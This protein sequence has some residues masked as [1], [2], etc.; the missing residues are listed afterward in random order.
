[1]ARWSSGTLCWVATTYPDSC[2]SC[3]HTSSATSRKSLTSFPTRDSRG[4]P[5]SP[6]EN[7]HVELRTLDSLLLP[8]GLHPRHLPRRGFDREEIRPAAGG[9]RDDR[10][11]RDGA[12][13]AR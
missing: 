6:E 3:R 8:V 10:R 4:L 1:M 12:F 5:E 2:A 11:S 9:R 13:A 7:S